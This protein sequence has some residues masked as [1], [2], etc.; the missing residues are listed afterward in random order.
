MV[1]HAT[2]ESSSRVA[3]N[4]LAQQM[5]AT[6]ML[7]QEARHIMNEPAN[8]DERSI[9]ALRLE[10]IPR[11]NRHLLLVRRPRQALLFGAELL[12]LHR[13]LALCD[14]VLGEDLQVRREPEFLA[15]GDKPLGRVVLV[16]LDGVAVVHGELVVEVVVT[17]ADGDEG[18]D[19][20]VA[21]SVLVIEGSLAEPMGKGVD[22]ERRLKIL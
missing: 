20:V 18:G 17:L 7:V 16:P 21:G 12:Q 11:N 5:L 14:F 10:S 22:T 19:H 1:V 2:V 8:E 4:V 9:L 6:G 3:P 15:G 13:Q